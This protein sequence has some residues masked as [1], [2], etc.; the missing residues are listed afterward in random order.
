MTY[1][2]YNRYDFNFNH[3]AASFRFLDK[4]EMEHLTHVLK[5]AW[6]KFAPKRPIP[7][8]RVFDKDAAIRKEQQ[9]ISKYIRKKPHK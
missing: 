1:K 5:E 6:I 4:D 2:K 7:T 3:Y 8:G 9:D